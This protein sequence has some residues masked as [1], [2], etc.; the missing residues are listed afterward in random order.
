MTNQLLKNLTNIE[1]IEELTEKIDFNNLISENFNQWNTV[2][3]CLNKDFHFFE[4]LLFKIHFKRKKKLSKIQRSNII[5]FLSIGYL[6]SNDIR[7]LN[8]FLW[9]YDNNKENQEYYSLLIN[10]FKDNTKE[11]YHPFPLCSVNEVN[12]FIEIHTDNN[13]SKDEKSLNNA[14]IALVGP[15]FFFN[16]VYWKLV[17]EGFD[18]KVFSLLYDSNKLKRAFL[19]SGLFFRFYNFIKG[20]RFKYKTINFN[21]KDETIT[22]LSQRQEFEIGFHKLGF[23]LKQNLLSCFKKGLIN[24]HWGILPFIRGRSTIEYS[25]LFGFPLYVTTHFVDDTID[26]GGIVKLYS[27]ESLPKTFK[28][29]K[30]IRSIIKLGLEDRIYSSIKEVCSNNN[31]ICNEKKSG[32]TFYSI[33]DFLTAYIEEYLLNHF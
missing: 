14:K 7:Y 17:K 25:I 26:T 22:D 19:K 11:K 9:F 2:K 24:D 3:M 18:V 6:I 4:E 15:P 8:E 1:V 30:Q 12:K 28:S 13:E 21:P 33:H 23:I 29:V 10:R 16:K 20:V 5:K 27:Y 31:Q 32:L